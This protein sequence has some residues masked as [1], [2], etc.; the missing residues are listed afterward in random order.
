[1]SASF[2][3]NTLYTCLSLWKVYLY[4]FCLHFIDPRTSW[5]HPRVLSLSS[6]QQTP[7]CT[8]VWRGWP[9][10]VYHGPGEE[11]G[12]W[13]WESVHPRYHTGAGEGLLL[14][15]QPRLS[16]D[17]MLWCDYQLVRRFV[18]RFAFIHGRPAKAILSQ[19]VVNFISR[20]EAFVTGIKIE[21]S[22]QSPFWELIKVTSELRKSTNHE[23]TA[24]IWPLNH[25]KSSNLEL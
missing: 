19:G 13:V 17:T 6:R 22:D 21:S 14:Q 7:M 5:Q 23:R 9:C 2:Q 20:V 8:E 25:C 4:D 10:G 12:V 11:E 24:A 18:L 3:A 15:D 16:V 1:M